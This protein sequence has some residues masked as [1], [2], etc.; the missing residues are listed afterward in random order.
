MC[1]QQNGAISSLSRMK[2]GED[3]KG[4]IAIILKQSGNKST[5]GIYTTLLHPYHI[6]A[7]VRMCE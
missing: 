6:L 5:S 3:S 1:T 4:K 2:E 7:S